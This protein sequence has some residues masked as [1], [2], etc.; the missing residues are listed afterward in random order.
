M[1]NLGGEAKTRPAEEDERNFPAV[2][3]PTSA[4]IRSSGVN[5]CPVD[6]SK[7]NNSEVDTPGPDN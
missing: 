7:M 1:S 3:T 6:N 4:G 2:G 5:D